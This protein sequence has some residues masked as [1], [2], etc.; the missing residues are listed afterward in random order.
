MAAE[1]ASQGIDVERVGEWLEQNVD[2]AEGPF[3]YVGIAGGRSN[4]TYT[5]IGSGGRRWAL[6][7]PPMGKA[8]GSAHDMGREVTVVSAMAATD[9]PV[10]PI[11][12]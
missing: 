3:T 6:R 4:L 1:E 5:V 2:G 12:G 7:R 11:A 9:V 8:L 10:A